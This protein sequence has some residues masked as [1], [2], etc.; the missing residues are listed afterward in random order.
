MNEIIAFVARKS[1][2]KGV[3]NV[4]LTKDVVHFKLGEHAPD[5]KI[6]S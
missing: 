6:L 4:C 5:I 2:R 1:K 3:I